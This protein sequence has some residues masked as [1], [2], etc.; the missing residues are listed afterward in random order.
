MRLLYLLI[1]D[2]DLM[3]CIINELSLVQSNCNHGSSFTV[4]YVLS[5][6][7]KLVK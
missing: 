7:S 6:R 4:S 1:H 3:Y 5:V 2:C